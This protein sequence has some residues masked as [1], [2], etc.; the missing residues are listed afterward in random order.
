MGTRE[1]VDPDPCCGGCVSGLNPSHTH[2]QPAVT[3]A[4]CVGCTPGFRP[5]HDGSPRCESGSTASGGDK[6]H[7]TCDTCF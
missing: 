1:T 3:V 6:A 5:S 7:C 4:D 2:D